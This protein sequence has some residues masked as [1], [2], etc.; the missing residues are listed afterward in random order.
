MI[1]YSANSRAVSVQ[2]AML[3]PVVRLSARNSRP[4]EGTF[5]PGGIPSLDPSF[6]RLANSLFGGGLSR[7][8]RD[9]TLAWSTRKRLALAQT[10]YAPENRNQAT[11]EG[12]GA[13]DCRVT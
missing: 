9:R 12:S 5:P 3:A 13:V 7:P 1:I 11:W 10:G 6:R 4:A 2:V 8:P